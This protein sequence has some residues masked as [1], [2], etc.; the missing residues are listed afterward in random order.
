MGEVLVLPL[1]LFLLTETGYNASAFTMT[2]GAYN[3]TSA[4]ASAAASDKQ[5]V[6]SIAAPGINLVHKEEFEYDE[7]DADRWTC[8]QGL[9]IYDRQTE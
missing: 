6:V 8:L 5:S 2:T 3:S 7:R 4:G 1:L 9:R